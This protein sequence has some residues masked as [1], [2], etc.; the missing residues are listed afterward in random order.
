MG[1]ENRL[2][3][4][5][6]YVLF[7]TYVALLNIFHSDKLVMISA[8]ETTENLFKFSCKVSDLNK[9]LDILPNI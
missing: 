6:G 8:Q 1:L 3:R 2:L 9:N 4:Y 5:N 7:F